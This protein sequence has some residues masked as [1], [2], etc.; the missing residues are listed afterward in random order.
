MID[1]SSQMLLDSARNQA[2]AAKPRMPMDGTPDAIK[3]SAIEFEAVFAQQ[4]LEPMFAEVS[5]DSMF[6]GGHA[7]GIYQSM[8]VQE[9]GQLIAQQGSLGIAD[10]VA[11][12]MLKIQEAQSKTATN[13]TGEIS[14]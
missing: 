1:T 6:G 10:T 2:F 4:M 13:T 5:N 7:E 3:K 9:F 11:K 14:Q 8:M 12:E